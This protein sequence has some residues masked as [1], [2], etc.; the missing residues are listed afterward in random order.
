MTHHAPK[1]ATVA[2]DPVSVETAPETQ[3]A[4]VR[5][6]AITPIR[7]V[8]DDGSS[9]GTL[10]LLAAFALVLVVVASASMLRLLLELGNPRRGW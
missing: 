9:S 5:T 6:A 10:L 2:A 3:V 8:R 1:P 4:A 7:V